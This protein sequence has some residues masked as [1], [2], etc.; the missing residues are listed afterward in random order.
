MRLEKEKMEKFPYEY[1]QNLEKLEQ[2]IQAIKFD[3]TDEKLLEYK[4]MTPERKRSLEKLMQLVNED[5]GISD[6][7]FDAWSEFH[8]EYN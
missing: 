7:A 5:G 4:N 1:F 8:G 3:L 6:A 2:A